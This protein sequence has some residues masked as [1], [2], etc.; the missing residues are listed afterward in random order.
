[1][2]WCLGCQRREEK[3]IEEEDLG[4]DEKR[5]RMDGIKL[6]K[7]VGETSRSI[8]ERTWEHELGLEYLSYKTSTNVRSSMLRCLV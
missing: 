6:W 8:F 1:M 4:E 2:I 3:I 5:K 7:Y